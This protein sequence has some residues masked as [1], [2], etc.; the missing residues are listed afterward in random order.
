MVNT[1]ASLE[2]RL[3]RKK[4]VPQVDYDG[5][6]LA[7]HHTKESTYDVD[8]VPYSLSSVT[9]LKASQEN[10][11]EK[12]NHRSG[13]KALSSSRNDNSGAENDKSAG[14]VGQQKDD[15]NVGSSIV[16][17]GGVDGNSSSLKPPFAYAGAHKVRVEPS[18]Q[19][20]SEAHAAT[21]GV[22]P[23]QSLDFF[24]TVR[25][26]EARDDELR[27]A[28]VGS[29]QRS[30]E[31]ETKRAT[32]PIMRRPEPKYSVLQPS[33]FPII[34][35][36]ERQIVK[37]NYLDLVECQHLDPDTEQQIG[38][39]RA[40]TE[41][42]PGLDLSQDHPTQSKAITRMATSEELFRGY[43]KF[44]NQKPVSYAGHIP[45]HPRNLAA[46]T[47]ERNEEDLRRSYS[48]SIMTLATHGGGV[49]SSVASRSLQARMR[50]GKN[51]PP[52]N[53]LKPRN[54]ETIRRM[55]EGDMLQ[56][57]LYNATE[58]EKAMNFRDDN[59]SKDYF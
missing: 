21:R 15:G 23:E 39:D 45:M 26:I 4:V 38:Y 43:P 42:L 9:G 53:V 22:L 59:R 33:A 5:P 27:G 7:L 1:R 8:Y 6:S 28:R 52:N 18:S 40:P 2:S 3:P 36:H 17:G 49:Y 41:R 51:A 31:I 32:D 47:R 12:S 11:N 44:V 14:E 35:A 55:V 46:M 54:D 20:E 16:G 13:S 25:K 48:N 29:V 37:K 10:L 19:W 57:T 34:A 56:T 24:S 30:V 50:Q 58:E